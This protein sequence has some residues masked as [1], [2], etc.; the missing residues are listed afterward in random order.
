MIDPDQL[1]IF[2]IAAE[3]LNFSRTAERLNLSQPSITQNI[4]ALEKHFGAPLFERA[5]RRLVLT[6]AGLALIP[7]ARQMVA[8][9]HRTDVLMEALKGDIHGH[10][11]IGCST[12]P[13]KYI[14]PVMLAEFMRQ[15]PRVQAT[16]NVT[17]RSQAMQA[18]EQGHVS[19]AFSS[20]PDEFNENI[21]FR[22]FISDPVVLITPP[23]HPWATL[24]EIDV[25]ELKKMPL[26]MRESTAG[27]YRV[28]RLGLA[29]LGVNI[30]ALRVILTLG[31]SE[32]IAIAVQQG[33]GV[34]FISRMV[35]QH[36]LPGSVSIIKVKGL[37]LRQD[38]YICQH[39][40]HPMLRVQAA[41]WDFAIHP[42]N[43]ILTNLTPNSDKTSF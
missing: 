6:E 7:L 43:P 28:V 38:I 3:T 40:L 5:G 22:K 39:R 23:N 18:L 35:I 33:L 12:T 30:E 16:C 10:L 36:I 26:I 19:I 21:E 15:H 2:L 27:T 41:F 4:H 9:S 14:L 42:D 31:N 11:H 24:G 29:Q 1:N 13:G 34:G 37:E 20:T 17:S 25:E 32:A 8:V